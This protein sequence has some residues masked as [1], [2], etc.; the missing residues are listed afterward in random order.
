MKKTFLLIC[1][2]F[3]FSCSQESKNM[4]NLKF[5][6]ET[7]NSAP[8]NIR[9]IDS[10]LAEDFKY[11]SDSISEI[12]SDFIKQFESFDMLDT[13]WTTKL[14]KTSESKSIIKTKESRTG[15]MIKTLDIKPISREREYIFNDQNQIKSIYVLSSDVPEIFIKFGKYFDTWAKIYYPDLFKELQKKRKNGDNYFD[16]LDFLLKKLKQDGFNMLDSARFVY[17][18]YIKDKG[19][20]NLPPVPMIDYYFEKILATFG[21]IAVQENIALPI[22]DPLIQKRILTVAFSKN[23]FSY[24]K[25]LHKVAEFGFTVQ[26]LPLVQILLAPIMDLESE[27]DIP[28]IY[29]GQ[30]LTDVMQIVKIMKN[31]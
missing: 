8:Y 15:Y 7:T 4:R 24:P 6:I 26:Q 14:D 29:S 21:S 9:L 12:K 17:E 19:Q 20:N 23:G 18:D 25:T 28:T 22:K 3:L 27:N 16:E 30:E 31:Y 11:I 5:F 13:F 2:F 10:L 1:I